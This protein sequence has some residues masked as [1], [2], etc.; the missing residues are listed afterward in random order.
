MLHLLYLERFREDFV[1]GVPT[2]ASRNSASGRGCAVA[3]G[4]V[5][6][7]LELQGKCN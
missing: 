2:N 7:G 6:L 5:A 1:I 3:G 4:S